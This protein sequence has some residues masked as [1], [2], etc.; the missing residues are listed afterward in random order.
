MFK[1]VIQ[2]YQDAFKG[3]GRENWLLSLVILIN[4]SGTMAIVFMSIYVTQVLK[5][6]LTQAG[7]IITV[8][9]LGA[10]AGSLAGGYLVD[11]IGF[12]TVQI[13]SSLIS[14]L[15][16]IVFGFIH[17]FLLLCVT[18]ALLGCIAEAMRPANFAAIASYANPAN[19]TK[20]YS[21]NRFAVN[22]GFGLGSIIGGVLA[23]IDYH[24]LFWVE[25]ITYIVVA[26]LIYFLLPDKEDK[27]FAAPATSQPQFGSPLHDV[28]FMKFLSLLLVYI[29]CFILVFKLA[30]VYW[31]AHAQMNESTIGLLLGLNGLL[32]GLFEMVLVQKLQSKGKDMNF[33]VLGI[34]LTAAGFVFLL[35]PVYSI[36]ISA[37]MVIV[38]ITF[39]EMF[40]LPFVNTFIIQRSNNTNK[41]KYA[42]AYSLVWSVANVIGPAGGAL[43]A[44]KGSYSLLWIIVIALCFFSGWGIRQM[45]FS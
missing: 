17:D 39:G 44:E 28:V 21:L 12:R 27:K 25:G 42:A 32:I 29:T 45:S 11:K 10:V 2:T 7:L 34:I 23:A 14:G 37:F 1:N 18:A 15:L 40:S 30:P 6:S 9:G 8:F 22:I 19:L 24:L 43:I 35:V 38:F 13:Q 20:S 4:R 33:I 41:G 36:I 26:G 16:F 31:K 3:I 5:Y